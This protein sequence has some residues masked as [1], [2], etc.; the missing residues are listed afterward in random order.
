MLPRLSEIVSGWQ[1]G[2]NGP[3]TVVE[4]GGGEGAKG[5]G[6]LTMPAHR[7]LVVRSRAAPAGP[8]PY[9]DRFASGMHRPLEGGRKSGGNGRVRLRVQ[10]SFFAAA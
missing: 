1:E 6:T 10:R 7:R 3:Q 5:E 8:H 2:P 9:L 4:D